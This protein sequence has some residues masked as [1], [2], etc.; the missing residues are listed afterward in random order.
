MRF[1][2]VGSEWIP[3][4]PTVTPM[5]EGIDREYIPAIPEPG[6]DKTQDK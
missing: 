6:V 2:G 4:C 1:D 3:A 5:F